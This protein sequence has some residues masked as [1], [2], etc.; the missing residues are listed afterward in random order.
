MSL[1]AGDPPLK[2]HPPIPDNKSADGDELNFPDSRESDQKEE[3]ISIGDGS[4]GRGS[5]VAPSGLFD[6]IFV[7]GIY[8][9]HVAKK[10]VAFTREKYPLDVRI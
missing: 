1:K 3:E 8:H 7:C 2:F 5:L 9:D 4:E 10:R 6:C